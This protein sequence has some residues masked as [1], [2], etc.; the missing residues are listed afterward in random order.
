MWRNVKSVVRCWYSGC[1]CVFPTIIEI[2]SVSDLPLPHQLRFSRC[3]LCVC[4]MMLT[5]CGRCA[6]STSLALSTSTDRCFRSRLFCDL[7]Q[8]LGCFS[9][10]CSICW[11]VCV[12]LFSLPSGFL[13][14]P[15]GES[16]AGSPSRDT[17]QGCEEQRSLVSTHRSSEESPSCMADSVERAIDCIATP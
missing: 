13:K 7:L 4:L 6:S 14:K 10:L 15:R 5:F 16:L 8:L 17:R 11:S 3:I 1:V 12:S 9:A 2:A